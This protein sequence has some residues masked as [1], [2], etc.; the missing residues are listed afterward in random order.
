VVLFLQTTEK[1]DRRGQTDRQREVVY[2][3]VVEV[4]NHPA[5]LMAAAEQFALFG[6]VQHVSSHQPTPQTFKE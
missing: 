1:A 2:T 4:V 6:P 5:F 3:A